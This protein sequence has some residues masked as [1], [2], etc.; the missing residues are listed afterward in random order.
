MEQSIID[1]QF[2]IAAKQQLGLLAA[3]V[4]G[5]VVLGL[6]AGWVWDKVSPRLSKWWE[7]NVEP[8]PHKPFE[9]IPTVKLPKWND[10]PNHD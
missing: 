8:P 7:E 10:K 2:I 9:G 1:L 3:C 4:G 5:A 6:G